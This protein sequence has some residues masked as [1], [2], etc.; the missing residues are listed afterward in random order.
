MLTDDP[1]LRLCA[2]SQL[3]H[4]ILPGFESL[5]LGGEQLA[6]ALYTG[7]FVVFTFADLR[8]DSSFLTLLFESAQGIFE[9]FILS[10]LNPGHALLSLL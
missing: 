8:E 1:A 7:L 4:L 10:H 6:F 9:G 2:Q 5:L 3:Y